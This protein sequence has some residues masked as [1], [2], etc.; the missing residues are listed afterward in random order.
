MIMVAH[1]HP[2]LRFPKQQAVR[3]VRTVFR[4][5]GRRKIP[6]VSIVFTD[7]AYIEKINGE[8][9]N[10]YYPTDVIAFPLMDE[11]S[12]EAE[13]YVNLDA[14]RR[15]AKEYGVS[16][17]NEITRL[18]IHGALHLIG[19]NDASNEQRLAMKQREDWYLE[20]IEKKV[21]TKESLK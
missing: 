13:L 4:T 16:Y 19:Y 7:D 11:M 21:C 10:H 1:T 18:L 15:Q 3:I 8:Y 6:D 17:R 20:R 12:D 9:L 14:G 2:F 5:E